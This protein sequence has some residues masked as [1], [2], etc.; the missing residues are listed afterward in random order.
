MNDYAKKFLITLFLG[1][2]GV[3]KFMEGK[4][5]LGI[6]YLCTLGLFG[7][8]WFFD[9]IKLAAENPNGLTGSIF[10][11]NNNLKVHDS[12]MRSEGIR[13]INE[14]KL[15]NI[16]G[17]NLNLEQGETCCYMDKGYTFRDKTITTG[18]TGKRNGVSFRIAKGVSYHTGASG[19]KAIR[20][21]ERTTYNG[22]LYI[23]TKRVIFTSEKDCFDKTFDKITLVQ[24]AQDG[25]V[26]QIGSNTYSIVTKT[27]AE[28]MKVYNLL[29]DTQANGGVVPDK[30]TMGLSSTGKEVVYEKMVAVTHTHTE[31]RQKLIKQLIK[32]DDFLKS[33]DYFQNDL[34]GCDADIEE[35]EM[36]SGKRCINVI[37][38]R[39]DNP[40]PYQVGYLDDA[41]IEEVEREVKNA[42]AYSIDLFV[43]TE[44]DG[45]YSLQVKI[46]CYKL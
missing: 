6:V 13:V 43:S 24:E 29:K 21:T 37:V 22:I 17:T 11:F 20:E 8:G 35:G 41:M 26:I 46:K 4:K 38:K 5:A 3:H 25:I 7:F 18:Y 15:P 30:Y 23:T 14:G 12:L 28:F 9:L 40:Y 44:D 33:Q 2:F 45:K 36:S 16:Q 32:N 39:E 27:H 1:I 31:G 42:G 10:N 19:S 34:I